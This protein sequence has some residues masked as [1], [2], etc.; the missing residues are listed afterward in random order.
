M[1]REISSV[2]NM[3]EDFRG[4]A[5][6]SVNSSTEVQFPL[7]KPFAKAVLVELA[8]LYFEAHRGLW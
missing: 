7:K 2:K 4:T 1:K 6:C 3:K 8:K 5:V